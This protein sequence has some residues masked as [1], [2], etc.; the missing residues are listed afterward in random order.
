MGRLCLK[1]IQQSLDQWPDELFNN[2]GVCRTATAIMGQVSY[3]S[4]KIKPMNLNLHIFMSNL[5][6]TKL[7][8]D[9]SDIEHWTSCSRIVHMLGVFVNKMFM[10]LKYIFALCRKYCNNYIQM[11][12][13]CLD[14]SCR[15]D[16]LER[17]TGK[18]WT[19]TCFV[20]FRHE[21]HHYIPCACAWKIP[22]LL[23]RCNR[24]GCTH[25]LAWG[26]GYHVF[27]TY[28]LQEGFL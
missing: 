11:F 26:Q 27:C 21:R 2:K 10:M 5:L 14:A 6:K 13:K 28:A 20:T 19:N 24:I 25:N 4:W 23:I 9:S 17:V 16:F 7:A 22:P 18:S 8:Y 15:C 12:S 1:I 3:K